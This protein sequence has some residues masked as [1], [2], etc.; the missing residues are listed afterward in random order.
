MKPL[1]VRAHL[2]FGIAQAAPWGIAGRLCS[3]RSC[4]R[5]RGLLP[6]AGQEYVR[7]ME[8]DDPPD[9][10]SRWRGAPRPM[11]VA[12]GRDLRLPDQDSGGSMSTWTGRVD[13]G[14]LE[15]SPRD[16]RR[17]SLTDRDGSGPQD[18][19][20]G[21]AVRL[22]DLARRRRPDRDP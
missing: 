3:P 2:A 13:A 20:V 5:V 4:G 8:R 21:H 10:T 7:A 17:R 1:K 11:A 12:L 19:A 16:C 22:S 14:A 15:R 18:A 6:G 9:L